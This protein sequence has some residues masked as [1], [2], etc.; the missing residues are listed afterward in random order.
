MTQPTKHIGII[1]CSYEG[2]ALCY[3]TVCNEGSLSMGEHAH[4]EIS[5]HTHPL[6]EYMKFIEADDWRG[7]AALMRSSAQ[8][9]VAI[10]AEV[11]I[12]PDN[13]IHR[14]FARA[15]EGINVPWLHIAREVAAAAQASSFKKT[16]ILGTKYLMESEVYPEAFGAHGIGYEVPGE[17]QRVEIN[18][19][20]FDEL[21]Y[22][23]I[24]ETSRDYLLTVIEDLKTRGCDSAVLGCTEIPLIVS[25]AASPLPVLDSTRLL[26]R[27]ALRTATA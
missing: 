15:S 9:L 3:R 8:K 16:G 25:P 12:C 10:G 19:I 1:A 18:R 26:A 5:L 23:V 17:R 13:T 22:G 7:V 11:L 21:V 6:N 14:S 2:A 4:P 20:I 27:A 24:K